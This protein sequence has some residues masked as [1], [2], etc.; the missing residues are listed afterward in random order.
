MIDISIIVPI[1]NL[2]NKLSKCIES[3]LSQTFKNIEIILVNDGS[4]DNSL[5][6]CR[7]YQN[8]DKRIIV[9]DISNSG[10]EKARLKGLEKSCGEYVMY[11][12]GD[13]WLSNSACELPYNNLKETNA[14]IVIG[15]Y[16]RVIGK[17]GLIK[18][19]NREV[20]NCI[21]ETP[22]LFEEFYISFFGVNKIPVTMWGKLYR[23]ELI[24]NNLPPI[25]G[26]KHG[27]D[28]CF[29][30]HLFPFV[31]K[32]S[33]ISDEIYYYRYGGMTNKMN[34]SIFIDACKAYEIKM[35]YL[36]RYNYFDRAGIYTAIELKNFLNTYIINYFIYTN[37]NKKRIVKEIKEAMEQTSFKAA[38]KLINYSAKFLCVLNDISIMSLLKNVFDNEKIAL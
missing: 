9:I 27:E 13:D 35:R 6:I 5:K 34:T 29:N 8:I 3:L 1:Y 36:D 18:K 24:I 38:L 31:N 33:I 32:I 21:I 37:Y 15:N 17:K 4:K 20:T 2:E 25:F 12:D 23:R 22:S 19:N 7:Y 26:L 30:M 16:S 10:V 28:L 14:D 11:V